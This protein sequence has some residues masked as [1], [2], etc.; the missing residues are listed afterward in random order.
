MEFTLPGVLKSG[1][2]KGFD[3]W[4]KQVTKTPATPQ[5]DPNAA[6]IGIR[7]PLR[8]QTPVAPTAPTSVDPAAQGRRDALNQQAAVSAGFSLD[9]RR[10]MAAGQTLN[11]IVPQQ[12]QLSGFSQL[13]DSTQFPVTPTSQDLAVVPPP[14]QQPPQT[15]VVPTITKQPTSL[16]QLEQKYQENL[17]PSAEELAVSGEMQ[18][19]NEAER[20]GILRVQDQPIAL[21]F[22]TGQQAAIERRALAQR[23]TLAERAAIAQAKRQMALESSKFSL[24]REDKKQAEQV[25]QAEALN[26]TQQPRFE[27]IGGNLVRIDANGSVTPVY[28]PPAEG[29]TP[30]QAAQLAFERE[31]MQATVKAPNVEQA[32]AQQF[33]MNASQANNLLASVKYDP[34]FVESGLV[35]NALKSAERQQF[36]QASRAFVNAVLRR[37]S[38][39]TIT[40]D[41]FNNKFKEL[42][43]QAG[44]SK[45]VKEQKAR[46]RATAIEGIL[47]ATSAGFQ[48]P[49]G[50]T[51]QSLTPQQY[52]QI[53]AKYPGL[54]DEKINE[55][56]GKT[57]D[58]SMSQN[59]SVDKFKQSIV[60]QESG[61]GGN[62]KAVGQVPAGYAEADRALGKYQIVPKYH[63]GKIG[64]ANTPENRQKF[65]NS[66]ALQDKVFG[67]IIDENLKKYNGNLAK[68]AAAY[69]GGSAGAA[70]VGTKAGDAPQMAGGKK[71]PSI[72]EY[73]N[74][75]LGRIS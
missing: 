52:Q 39:A 54:S 21:D 26:K 48:L 60:Q 62:Y 37:E 70:K 18:N 51:N 24:E 20:Q 10:K 44:D 8:T 45:E 53:K 72:N 27:N 75:V 15:P 42:I 7:A 64:L 49:S 9:T 34:G 38:G 16:E 28:T 73:V 43:P 4:K 71:F 55:I 29:L 13:N 50:Q 46:A 31:K 12:P 61:K 63:F 5:L 58:P 23:Q 47:G 11:Q 66:P 2:Q 65:L 68:A 67:M 17:A 36:E 74:S 22:I 33:A 25:K 59:G 14:E 30:Y 40:D 3:Y 41:E 69:Y 35:P 56:L 32:K 1:I 6:A 57:N 19:L